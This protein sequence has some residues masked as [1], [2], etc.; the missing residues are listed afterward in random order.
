MSNNSHIA[1]PHRRKGTSQTERF[2]AALSDSYVKIDERKLVDLIAQ[3]AEL[4][5]YFNYYESN[6]I[7]P[8]GSWQVFFEE[9]YDFDTQIVKINTIEELYEKSETKPHLALFLAFLQLFQHSISQLNSLGEKHLLFFYEQML[10]LKKQKAISPQVALFGELSNGQDE[11]FIP[12]NT[13]FKAGKNINGQERIFIS[14]EDT[15]LNQAQVKEIR[16]INFLK[17][18]ITQRNISNSVDG[19]G[20]E[21]VSEPKSWH[22]FGDHTD[23]LTEIGFCIASPL[24]LQN[25]GTRNFILEVTGIQLNNFDFFITTKEGWTKVSVLYRNNTAVLGFGANFP[26]IVAYNSELHGLN[27]KTIDPIIKIVVRNASKTNY[28]NLKRVVP[29][30]KFAINLS[31]IKDL[32]LKNELGKIDVSKPFQPFGNTPKKD[33]SELL[34]GHPL[35]F[36]KFTSASSITIQ[37][38]GNSLKDVS[39]MMNLNG[40]EWKNNK[41]TNFSREFD[42]DFNINT[43]DNY[44]KY[45]YTGS[46]SRENHIAN[47]L[48]K[49][50]AVDGKNTLKAS[51]LKENVPIWKDLSISAKLE[52]NQTNSDA[53]EFFHLHPFGAERKTQLTTLLPIYNPSSLLLIGLSDV[54]FGKSV[55]L[56]FE[57]L[58]GSGN[59]DLNHPNI[60][61]HVMTRDELV[62]LSNS[63][64]VKDTTLRLAQSGMIKFALAADKFQSNTVLNSDWVW[65]VASCDQNFEAI[66]E[67]IDILPQVFLASYIIPDSGIVEQIVPEIISK[68]EFPINGLK[69]IK[70]NY[71]SFGGRQQEN[72]QSFVTRSSEWLRHKGMAINLFDY[73]RILLQ[74]FPFLYSVKCISHSTSTSQLAPGNVLIIL[75]PELKNDNTQINLKPKVSLG[76]REKIKNYL[77]KITSPFIQLEVRNPTYQE[78]LVEV[79]VTYLPEFAADKAYY[80]T[81]LNQKL[82]NYISPWINRSGGIEFNKE[83]YV[84]SYINFIEELEFVDNITG[85][86]LYVDS[87]KVKN[88]IEAGKE[89]VIFTSALHHRISNESLC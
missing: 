61:W 39:A 32:T 18:Q 70:Q 73:E 51:D 77:Q 36:S 71:Q 62:P 24:F 12:K 6:K 11:V 34:I 28:E 80:N 49:I 75:L 31:D 33:I 67:F 21:F 37:Q 1:H 16:N 63:E 43:R 83:S 3:T 59:P 50:S 40:Q 65:L 84:S 15:V 26:E 89:D 29:K 86:S 5:R 68:P 48:N 87:V 17:N 57:M 13:R 88:K 22:A 47:M 60:S 82:Q 25:E 44:I 69:K 76:N 72:Q 74:E 8:D 78:I 30:F 9:I 10:Q 4:S 35:L 85:F 45:R 46:F 2:P 79:N 23:T 56:H 7:L 42:Q 81:V 14:D 20:G 27:F 41:P 64:I 19:N 52:F 58:E 38:N 55:S 53:F 54:K 66:P